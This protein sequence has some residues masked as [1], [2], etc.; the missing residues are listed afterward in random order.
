M[1]ANIPIKVDRHIVAPASFFASSKDNRAT[2]PAIIAIAVVMTIRFFIQSLAPLV[3]QIIAVSI[4]DNNPTAVNPLAKLAIS[5]IL[6]ST[7]TPAMIPIATAMA[8]N[9]PATLR[10]PGPAIFTALTIAIIKAPN[11]TTAA[12]PFIISLAESIP[13]SF[14]TPTISNMDTDI[15]NSSPL[16]F[17]IELPES[18]LTEFTNALTNNTN[19]PA[20]A[21]PLSISDAD[22]CP[23]SLTTPTI[24]VIANETDN[25]KAL[26]LAISV[27]RSTLT[28][29]F[30]PHTNNTNAAAN[31]APLSISSADK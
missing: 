4:A 7:L 17:A 15:D 25:S 10:A 2:A 27:P 1:I 28:A 9:V 31:A 16:T 21:T 8:V 20:N 29:F 22:N 26:S 6:S 19:A 18:I 24:S 12:V 13:T 3:A 23:A 14:I 30:I 5:T 11:A